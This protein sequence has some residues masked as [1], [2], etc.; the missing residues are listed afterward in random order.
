MS[1]KWSSVATAR[2]ARTLGITVA[3]VEYR[4]SPEHKAPVVLDAAYRAGNC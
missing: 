4:L 1:A 3:S 2:I